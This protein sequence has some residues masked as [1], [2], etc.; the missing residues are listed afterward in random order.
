MVIKSC[1][2]L[3]FEVLGSL[4]DLMGGSRFAEVE[5]LWGGGCDEGV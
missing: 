3:F 2:G 5:V 4:G 1:G